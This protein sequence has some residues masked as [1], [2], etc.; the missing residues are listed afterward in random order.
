MNRIYPSEKSQLK[1]YRNQTKTHAIINKETK[2]APVKTTA[3]SHVPICV[4]IF[5]LGHIFS[6]ELHTN[7][8]KHNRLLA[9]EIRQ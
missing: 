5:G 3:R 9:N 6:D 2:R 8:P 1:I 4:F 7:D